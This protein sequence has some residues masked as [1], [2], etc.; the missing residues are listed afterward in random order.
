VS[1]T[2]NAAGTFV[3]TQVAV[4]GPNGTY[5]ATFPG[6]TAPYTATPAGNTLTGYSSPGAGTANGGTAVFLSN[7]PAATTLQTNGT[8][9]VGQPVFFVDNAAPDAR[10]QFVSSNYLIGN[11]STGFVGAAFAFADSVYQGAP[12]TTLADNDGVDRVARSFYFAANAGGIQPTAIVS[13]GT[14]V[15]VG[16]SIPPNVSST[17]YVAAAH[18][19]DALGNGVAV[20]VNAVT[21]GQFTFGVVTVPPNAPTVA[22]G[23]IGANAQ[24]GAGITTGRTLFFSVSSNSGASFPQ[25][26]LVGTMSV[27]TSSGG[28]R[29]AVAADVTSGSITGVSTTTPPTCPLIAFNS[30]NIDPTSSQAPSGVYTVVAQGRDVAGN[31][32]PTFTRTFVIDRTAPSVI[33]PVIPTV[34]LTGGQAETFSATATDN[35]GLVNQI[36]AVSYPTTPE[37]LLRYTGTSL[38]TAF[39]APFT[40]GATQ[41]SVSMPFFIRG[42][43]LQPSTAP[44]AGCAPTVANSCFQ[45]VVNGAFTNAASGA[46]GADDP[47]A[48]WTYASLVASAIAN[49]LDQSVA[50]VAPSLF[51]GP[52][53]PTSLSL[54]YQASNAA[55]ASLG[56]LPAALN[57]AT[58]GVPSSFT[59]NLVQNG[60]AN[61]PITNQFS[62][63]EIWQRSTLPAPAPGTPALPFGTSNA[64]RLVGACGGAAVSV[65]ASASTIT[66]SCAVTPGGS[67]GG[68]ISFSGFP[69]SGST[70]NV[71]LLLVASTAN[72]HAVTFIIPQVAFTTP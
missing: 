33:N 9:T 16:G 15:A 70:T 45:N 63:V 46:I 31:L 69:T 49:A 7:T 21:G 40:S 13:G 57:P 10:A 47:A 58:A 20:P 52:A 37:L 71:N 11:T 43:A 14:A 41:L 61:T 17:A 51:T 56:G 62:K 72:G 19:V 6:A 26:F 42:V 55:S 34:P 25:N 38:G 29:C 8:P 35:F 53:A 28:T 48:N 2:N 12:L 65:S 4:A 54:T 30:L 27:V 50:Q 23:N 39:A 22:F 68:E 24:I 5:V 44:S 64:Y 66:N 32:G 3:A 67:L 36:A 1:L 60:P 18:L 59:I